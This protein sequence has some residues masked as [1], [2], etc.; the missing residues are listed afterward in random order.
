MKQTAMLRKQLQL[1]KDIP[2]LAVSSE[3]GTGINELRVIINQ[4]IDAC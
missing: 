2:M 4:Y 1:D 3:S